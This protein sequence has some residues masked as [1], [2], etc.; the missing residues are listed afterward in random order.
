M[1][2]YSPF[3]MW[4]G[5][6]TAFL[7]E[8]EAIMYRESNSADAL[9]DQV[10]LTAGFPADLIESSA[11]E[12]HVNELVETRDIGHPHDVFVHAGDLATL[13]G[14]SLETGRNW[15]Q[16]FY[17][18]GLLR[19]HGNSDVM[20]DGETE[21]V[22]LYLPVRDD[23]KRVMRTLY[24]L[25]RGTYPKTLG[26][27]DS[28]T[29]SQFAHLGGSQFEYEEDSDVV[30]DVEKP[31]DRNISLQDYI[32]EQLHAHGVTPSSPKNFVYELRKHAALI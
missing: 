21:G 5:V 30:I 20:Y 31:E 12:A 6:M 9:V 13:T 3:E 26:E 2:R 15:L 17:E 27:L 22:G 11:T 4:T 1:P 19:L 29:P 8:N 7:E 14:C 24:E 28:V 16:K 18:R 25:E 32:N 23:G 10:S